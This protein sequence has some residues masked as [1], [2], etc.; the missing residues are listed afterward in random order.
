MP[1]KKES[2]AQFLHRIDRTVKKKVRD[3]GPTRAELLRAIN[4]KLRRKA[5]AEQ[6]TAHHG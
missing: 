2:E 5:E 3:G 6:G 4:I 1:R